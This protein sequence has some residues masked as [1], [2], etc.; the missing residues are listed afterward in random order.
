MMELGFVEEHDPESDD[1]GWATEAIHSGCQLRPPFVWS[2]RAA[3]AVLTGKL[4][5]VLL[6]R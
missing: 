5:L 3:A 6:R 2:P 1:P 4:L